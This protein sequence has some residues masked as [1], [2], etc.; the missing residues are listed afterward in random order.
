MYVKKN[1]LD[2]DLLRADRFLPPSSPPACVCISDGAG[3]IIASSLLVRVI[4]NN[5][6]ALLHSSRKQ[7]AQLLMKGGQ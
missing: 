7:N 1:L 4:Y 3:H 5:P 6:R 2:K